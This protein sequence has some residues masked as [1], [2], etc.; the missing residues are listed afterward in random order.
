MLVPTI[1][2]GLLGR[3]DALMRAGRCTASA[4]AR[5]IGTT[6]HQAHQWRARGR[7]P[8]RWCA[9]LD[10]EL[11]R[12]EVSD[13]AGLRPSAP[14][15]SAEP[16]IATDSTATRDLPIGDVTDTTLPPAVE[17]ARDLACSVDSTAL[18]AAADLVAVVLG[19]AGA[20][21]LARANLRRSGV[22]G[23]TYD[24]VAGALDAARR[25]LLG[26]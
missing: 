13:A 25:L 15:P 12:L 18:G 9:A 17:L 3:L 2:A 22:T 14:L 4:V 7:V 23:R 8:A 6:P 11:R 16:A 10:A 24:L 20:V 26:G 5:A 1:D 19:A 21:E